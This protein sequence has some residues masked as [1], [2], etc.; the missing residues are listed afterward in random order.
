M[1]TFIHIEDLAL[2]ALVIK[3]EEK[4]EPK[5]D[6]QTLYS[7]S[8]EVVKKYIN[9]SG[10]GNIVSLFF[11]NYVEEFEYSYHDYFVINNGIIELKDLSD[12]KDIND[13]WAQLFCNVEYDLLKA[14]MCQNCRN[15]L[16]VNEAKIC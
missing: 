5:V 10:N 15:V 14:L 4:S 12:D 11:K 2:A 13:L 7:Y 16:L 3:M 8:S 6:Y 9:Q 1:T